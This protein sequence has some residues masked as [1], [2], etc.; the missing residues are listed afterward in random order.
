MTKTPKIL[1]LLGWRTSLNG[2][3][4]TMV[5][6]YNLDALNIPS[7]LVCYNDRMNGA[8][9]FGVRLMELDETDMRGSNSINYLDVSEKYG[10]LFDV[11]SK[12]GIK[13]DYKRGRPRVWVIFKN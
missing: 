3:E 10:I 2:S 4:N 5:D 7:G 12:N 6:N 9:Y 11:L 8:E 1:V 13:M